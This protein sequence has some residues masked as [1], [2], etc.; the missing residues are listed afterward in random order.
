[1]FDE[2]CKEIRLK[3][4]NQQQNQLFHIVLAPVQAIYKYYWIK[5][6]KKG[7]EALCL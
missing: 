2:D 5:T 3:A 1:M 6:D 7:N 4:G